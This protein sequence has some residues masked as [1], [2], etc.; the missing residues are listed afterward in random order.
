MRKTKI[1]ATIGPAS[2]D[3]K[4]I[5]KMMRAGMDA[6]RFNFSHGT[7]DYHGGL[8][9]KV[10]EAREK[11]GKP[12]PLILDTK[13]P[14]IRTKTFAEHDKIFLEQGSEFTL[15]TEDIEGDETRVS[16]TYENLPHE[17]KIGTRI[18]IDDGLLELSVLKIEGKN[19]LCEMINSGFLGQR[20][21][22]NIPDVLLNLPSLTDKDVE[23]IK[24]GITMEVDWI[25]A[26]FVRTATDVTNIRKVLE[27]HGGR[28]IQIMAKI[29][30]RDGVNNIE[31]ILDVVDGVMVARGDLGVE[32][33]PEE[34][35]IVQKDLIRRCI[36]AGKPVVTATHMLES[37]VANPRPTRAEANDVANAIFDGSDVIMLSG[38]TANGK[39]PVQAIEMMSRI[40]EKTENTIDYESQYASRYQNLNKNVTNAISYSAVATAKEMGAECIVPVT[41]SG[42]AA[43]MVS[44]SRPRC[45]I[46]AAT[47]DP[48]VYRQLN[49]LWGCMPML[50]EK[51][52]EGDSEVF[53]IAEEL[54]L[55][56]G[57]VKNGDIMVS[58]AG[59]PVGKAGATNT[60]RVMTIGDV[61]AKGT[62]NHRGSVSGV[63]RVITGNNPDETNSFEKGN[64]MIC[65][66][67]DD[68]ML[69]CMKMAGGIVIG[70]WEKLDFSHAETVAKAL[71]IPLLRTG[72]RVVDFVRSGI[73]VTVDTNDGLLLNGNK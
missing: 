34:V 26:S 11:L 20:K 1:L 55:K 35:P 64:I 2:D 18:L 4:I 15:T 7:H 50:S 29:E 31:S 65:T 32:I 23:D 40:A 44:R 25:A 60:I 63:T 72:V 12:I 17:L 66:T 59:V 39:Y 13:G 46:L 41:D 70:S 9:N 54:A 21:G 73:P 57:L 62:G 71:N 43:R 51:P 24:F 68:S 47:S 45:P 5:T 61:L 28:H 14:E 27:Q 37:M 52:F 19:I 49:L 69:E 30:S 67:T 10:K 48:V 8:I 22:I 16:V 56:S 6:A 3:I 38:E 58:L 53:D 42:Y 33:P 36:L